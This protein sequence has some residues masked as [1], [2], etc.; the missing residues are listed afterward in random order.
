MF[1]IRLVFSP[2]RIALFLAKVVG[3]S[4]FG[5]FLI[6]VGVGLLLAPTTGAELRA[7][8]R[9]RLEAASSNTGAEITSG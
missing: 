2:L 1:L 3:Y 4:R 9:E 6:G 8:L 7:K 5:M